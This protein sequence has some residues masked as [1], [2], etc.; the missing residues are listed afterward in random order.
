MAMDRLLALFAFL[1]LLCFLMILMLKVGRLDL[2]I[3]IVVTLLMAAYDLFQA[4]S[5]RRR[6]DL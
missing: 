4:T 3:V 5:R 6:K 2:S 1:I